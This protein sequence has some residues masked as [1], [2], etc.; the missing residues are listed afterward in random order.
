M[1]KGYLTP[2]LLAVLCLVFLPLRSAG[3]VGISLET[4]YH[5]YLRYEP[6]TV[7]ILLRNY[8]GNTLVFGDNSSKQGHL[9][10]IVEKEG[11]MEV[12]KSDP[13]VNPVGNLILGAG[14]T[15]QLS[16]S[17]NTIYDMQKEGV[18]TLAAQVGHHRLQNDFRSNTITV[19]I[20]DGVVVW[21]RRAGIPVG[22]GTSAINARQISLLLFHGASGDIYCLRVEDDEMVYSTVR[23][24]PRIAGALPECDLDA[25]SNVHILF[26]ARPRLYAYRVYDF[27]GKLKQEKYLILEGKVPH[28]YRDPD[29]GRIIVTGGRLAVPGVDFKLLTK[30]QPR[31][32]VPAPPRR[33]D[34]SRTAPPKKRPNKSGSIW[35][36]WGLKWP[37][38][39]GRE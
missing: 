16:L 7:Q 3:Q 12:R 28:I 36:R 6:I 38:D 34:S 39:A 15:K 26:Q 31:R 30:Q 32:K 21:Q 10:F 2:V 33:L 8:S 11:A 24:G 23:L 17:L 25:V 27:N 19:E 22:N 4:E 18:Y 35:Q 14:E 29:I 13:K 5:K 20:A 37:G 9:D 1:K